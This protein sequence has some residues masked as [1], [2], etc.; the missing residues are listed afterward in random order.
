[1]VGRVISGLEAIRTVAAGEPPKVPDLMLKVRVVGDL[2]AAERARLQ[3][4]DVR[5]TAFRARLDALKRLK[6]PAFTV[7]DVE[8]P[9]RLR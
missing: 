2:P 8:I 4:M 9:T 1:M 6:G 3:V 5:P 7:C